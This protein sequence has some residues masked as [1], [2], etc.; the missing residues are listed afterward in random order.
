MATTHIIHTH[1]RR[2]DT[3]DRNGSR[4]ASLLARARGTTGPAMVTGD[5]AAM[6][7]TVAADTATMVADITGRERTRT[8]VAG[9]AIATAMR[10]V[11]WA[12]FMV[13]AG[14]VEQPHLLNWKGWRHRLPAFCFGQYRVL[15]HL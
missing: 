8:G 6:A 7:T 4:A 12:A 10:A 2:M 11:Q 14:A 13:V 9:L 15:I 1:V 3:T 5:A